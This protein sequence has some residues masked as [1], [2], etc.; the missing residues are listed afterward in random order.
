MYT[1]INCNYK[2]SWY[3]KN[4]VKLFYDDFILS[5]ILSIPPTFYLFIMEITIADPW[6]VIHLS[7]KSKFFGY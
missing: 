1:I 2:W 6:H 4:D 7:V 5:I 3:N